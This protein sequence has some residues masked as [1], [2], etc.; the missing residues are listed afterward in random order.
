MMPH[1]N[2]RVMKEPERYGMYNTFGLTYTAIIDKFD[3]D[4]TSYSKAMA[5]FKET[6]GKKPWMS[7]YNRCIQIAFGLL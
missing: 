6:Y 2:G 3:D 1:R 5:S 4:P 7:K